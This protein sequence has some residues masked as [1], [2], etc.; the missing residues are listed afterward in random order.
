MDGAR[1]ATSTE[2]NPEAWAARVEEHGHGFT[3][4]T[5]LTR[6]EEADEMLL[7]GLR[8]AEGLNLDRLAEIG[9]VRPGAAAIAELSNLGMLEA[10][11]VHDEDGLDEIRGCIGPAPKEDWSGVRPMPEACLRH[12]GL[13]PSRTPARIRATGHGRFILNELVLRLSRSF[14]PVKTPPAT[15]A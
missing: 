8:L 5:P 13:T 9:G 4:S 14:E 7:M 15:G 6:A 2:R 10:V 11:S 1:H 12:E 3:E